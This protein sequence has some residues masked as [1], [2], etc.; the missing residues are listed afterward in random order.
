[1]EKEAAKGKVVLV[2][3][4][5]SGCTDAL[6]SGDETQFQEMERRHRDIIKR[7]FTG[8][9]RDTL[10]QRLDALFQEMRQSPVE[11]QVTFGEIF[12]TTILSAKLVTEGY[13]TVAGLPGTGN[14]RQRAAHLSEYP[15]IPTGHR[16]R[17]LRGAGLYLPPQRGGVGY[18]GARWIG[19]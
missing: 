4:A 19:L 18:L 6:L 3:S 16:G 10:Q 14:Q 17:Y 1:M 7:L 5:I 8:E 12:S 11:E 9:D 2:S 15:G 13:K